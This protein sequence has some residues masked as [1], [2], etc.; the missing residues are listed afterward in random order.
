[1]AEAPPTIEIVHGSERGNIVALGSISF[2]TDDNIGD[3]ICAGSNFSLASAAYS[4]PFDVRGI[5][6]NDAGRC[7]DDSGIRGLRIVEE[8]GIAAATVS[9]DSSEIGD[10]LSTYRDGIVSALNDTA[11]KFGVFEGLSAKEAAHVMLDRT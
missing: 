7:M 10:S 6:C 5:I 9:A 2:I 11:R 1:L 4:S 8:S 3:V